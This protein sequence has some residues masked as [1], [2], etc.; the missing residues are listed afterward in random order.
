MTVL[1][2]PTRTPHVVASWHVYEQSAPHWAAQESTL[3]HWA[4]HESPQE[5]LHSCVSWQL[6]TQPLPQMVP[7]AFGE[8]EHSRLHAFPGHSR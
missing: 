1:P 2:G 4:R 6:D 8:W 5:S 7:Q 3:W